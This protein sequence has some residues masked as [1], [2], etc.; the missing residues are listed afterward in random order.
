[1]YRPSIKSKIPPRM[2]IM[3]VEVAKSF[4]KNVAILPMT[5]ASPNRIDVSANFSIVLFRSCICDHNKDFD[6]KSQFPCLGDNRA[7]VILGHEK[8]ESSTK[9]NPGDGAH[10]I[11][12]EVG[13]SVDVR[14][15]WGNVF[16]LSVI[17]QR[18]QIVISAD[19]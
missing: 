11:G 9:M 19:F 7:T 17:L 3:L 4:T 13:I 16:G 15:F 8:M 12:Q 10:L 18:K 5:A 14:H 2:P 1:M 6:C